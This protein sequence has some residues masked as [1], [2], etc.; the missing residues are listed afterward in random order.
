MDNDKNEHPFSLKTIRLGVCTEAE[1]HIFDA[2]AFNY[3]GN[4]SYIPLATL[5]MSVQLVVSLR[6]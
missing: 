4:P 6:L 3:E 5:K 1:L 2:E